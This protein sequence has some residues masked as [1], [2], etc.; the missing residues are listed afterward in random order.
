MGV[1]IWHLRARRGCAPSIDN[2]SCIPRIFVKQPGFPPGTFSRY[3]LFHSAL[4]SA[5]S[6][7][8]CLFVSPSLSPLSMNSGKSLELCSPSTY[9]LMENQGD[10][11]GREPRQQERKRLRK[12][13]RKE[14]REKQRKQRRQRR[15]MALA[16]SSVCL[17]FILLN[18]EVAVLLFA[19][20]LTRR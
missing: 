12:A 13:K 19:P 11:G 20:A 3:R 5:D 4:S 8:S 7:Q 10:G 1:T 14:G 15:G 2:G 17:H 6:S 9:S 16:Y 18:R